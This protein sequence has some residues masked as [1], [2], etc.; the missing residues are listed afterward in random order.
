MI[1]KLLIFTDLDGTLLEHDSYSF[2]AARPALTRASNAGVPVIAATSKTAAEV[3]DIVRA[4]ELHA[5]AIIENGG[6][7]WFPDSVAEQFPAAVIEPGP[8]YQQIL[9]RMAAF[10]QKWQGYFIGFSAMSLDDV[11][12]HTGLE[13]RA[14]EKAKQRQYS[15]PG[16]WTGRDD[17]LAAFSQAVDDAGLQLL[18][19]GR[20][21]HI[22]GR[23]NK[24]T[25][26][27]R[28]EAA[29]ERLW[30]GKLI[31]TAA[32][33]DAPNDMEMIETADYGFIIANPNGK[34]IP[35]LQG[36]GRGRIVRVSETGPTGWNNAVNDLLDR[37]RIGTAKEE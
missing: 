11:M 28:L 3:C 21:F 17:E 14:A 27:Q 22:S 32:L 37:L 29:Y 5:P 2:D 12:K 33:G 4:M 15:E 1:T 23:A 10:D 30:P 34:H 7:I 26:M 18:Q 31:R 16:L 25:Q 9:A 8:T 6:G 36:E 20:F 24:A 19:G 13:R 35:E